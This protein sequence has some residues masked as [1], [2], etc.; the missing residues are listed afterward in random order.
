MKEETIT[1]NQGDRGNSAFQI[2]LRVCAKVCNECLFSNRK[3]VCDDRRDEILE[4]CAEEEK[5]F[6][7]HKHSIRRG[8]LNER[9]GNLPPILD[10]TNVTC[11]GF[12]NANPDH[13]TIAIARE[14]GLI[15][16]VDENGDVAD[17]ES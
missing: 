1:K 9:A 11:R 5:T 16:F 12:Y 13:P 2:G 17:E 8:N 14:F 15:I 6:E 10:D 7:C 3:V 4:G